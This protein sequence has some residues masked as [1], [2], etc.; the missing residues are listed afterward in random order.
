VSRRILRLLLASTVPLGLA[1][2]AVTGSSAELSP[3]L[4]GGLDASDESR[5][6][7][8]SG[9]RL[10]PS[11][12]SRDAV[13]PSD[14][15]DAGPD[16]RTAFDATGFPQIGPCLDSPYEM[17][18]VASGGYAGLDGTYG[19]DGTRGT[20]S[21]SILGES[22]LQLNIGLDQVE[23]AWAIVIASDYIEGH[24]LEPGTFVSGSGFEGRF[25]YAQVAVNGHACGDLPGGSFTLVDLG[26]TGGDQAAATTLLASFDLQ[27]G[28]A[29]H[30][31]GCVRY[32]R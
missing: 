31:R 17:H 26:T 14:G 13:A 10:S 18:V 28:D 9:S 24:F 3:E 27:C 6:P 19:I 7:D 16:A 2:G 15:S 5:V 29:G 30:L 22:F 4:P 20:W 32:G 23:P 25:P 8:A 12:A 21:S 1:C 11:D